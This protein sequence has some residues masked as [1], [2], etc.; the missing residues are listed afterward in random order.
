MKKL[1]FLLVALIFFTTTKAQIVDIPDANFKAKLLN[2]KF[3]II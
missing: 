1:Y 3:S 2:L